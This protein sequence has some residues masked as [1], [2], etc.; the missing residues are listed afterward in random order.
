[1]RQPSLLLAALALLACQQPGPKANPAP[2][3]TPSPAA[4]SPS[5]PVAEPTSFRFLE[6]ETTEKP[7]TSAPETPISLTASDGTGLKL[8]SLRAAGVIEEPL[9]FTELVMTFQN[10]Q[11]RVIEGQ[12]RI[13]LPVNAS[14]S[15]FA[16][17]IGDRWQE[18]EVVERQAARRAYEDFLHRRQ[19]PA[20]L[21]QGAANEFTARVFPIPARGI[22]E[23]IISY[24]QE[25]T[26]ADQKY[27]IPL[28]GLP[29]LGDL[30]IHVLVATTESKAGASSLGGSTLSHQVVEVKKQGWVPDA[31]FEVEQTHASGRL[32]LRH[33][34]LVV[35]RVT[36]IVQSE[37]EAIHSLL[38]LFDTSA[39]RALGFERQVGLL[40]KLVRGLEQGGGGEVPISVVAF[41]Q[42]VETVY[43]GKVSGFGEPELKK[44]R[45]WRALGASDLE[46]ALRFVGSRATAEGSLKYRR[47]VLLGDGI[48]TAGSTE[49]DA[50]IQAAKSMAGS[51]V[52]RF[53]AIALGGIRDE[54]M[55]AKLVTAGLARPGTVIDGDLPV[56]MVARK[57]TQAT[58]GV[59]PVSVPGASWV[60]PD[61]LEGFQAGDQALI[62]ADLP[63]EQP[64]QLALGGVAIA[65]DNRVLAEVERPLIE[66]AWVKARMSR[67]LEQRDTLASGDKDMRAAI[68]KQV[69]ELSIRHRVL[70]PYTALL[71]LETEADYARFHIDR[72]AL[73]DVLTVGPTGLTV[74]NR[75][76]DSLA[77]TKRPVSPQRNH[78]ADKNKLGEKDQGLVQAPGDGLKGEAKPTEDA[79]KMKAGDA[80][81][82]LE[83]GADAPAKTAAAPQEAKE[84]KAAEAPRAER[85]LQ[86]TEAPPPPP[87]PRPP[88]AAESVEVASS[89]RPEDLR[90]EAPYVGPFKGVMDLIARK[91]GKEAL[92][93]ASAWREE[94]PGDVMA[95][96]ALGEAYE[97][98]GEVR[99]AARAY[100]SLIDLFPS[101]ADL[102][103]FAGERLE[104]LSDR[105]AAT[106]AIDSYQKAVEQRP[107]HPASH[108]LYAFALVKNEQ[109]E[110]AFEA[111]AAGVK[112]S[113]P[114]GRFLGV[115]QILREDLGLI[116]RAWSKAEPKR[117]AEIKAKLSALGGSEENGPSLRFILNWETDANDV[118]FHIF[119]S[120]GG[121]AFYSSPEL[122][123]GGNLYA[124]VTT[125]YGPECFTIRGARKAR[126]HPYKLQAHYYSR[127]PMGY[128]MGKLQIIEHDG[129]GGLRF[130]ERPFVVMVDGAFVNL[131]VVK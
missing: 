70:S 64:L 79:K 116:A 10:P 86:A 107:D 41:D 114:D 71:V 1:M 54:A 72:R 109:Y 122:P 21:E 99:L 12:F 120:R 39:S 69:T 55:L 44:L 19:D 129:S 16:M 22:K 75:S 8:V 34:N 61:K 103:R 100:G 24:S 115:D 7:A 81:D 4:T 89:N 11:D 124:D 119:D 6:T 82:D 60:W 127:G 108:R 106:L 121:H 76:A 37:P 32:G 80:M 20:L 2:A 102:R 13:T 96:I 18:G 14:I 123:S 31:D 131:G 35:A 40:R 126:A 48:P 113:Y 73:A 68:T 110:R 28:V 87:A 59:I 105:D 46:R 49:G 93:K 101:R 57:L 62:Y 27:K 83:A 85:R 52:E 90:G 53:D 130:E 77:V 26:R 125:G 23:L 33:E 94:A 92:E 88:P 58:H 117:G 97:A 84:D 78:D 51:G 104:R 38:V 43:E 67:L 47:V 15:R 98:L 9:A 45:D 91:K 3:T 17:K 128:G 42:V 65:S 63:K 95:L 25:L 118:D 56:Q 29:Q 30:D 74:L 112:Q 50:L 66:R 36:P 5:P 111:M